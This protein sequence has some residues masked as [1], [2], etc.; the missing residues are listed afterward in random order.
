M[1]S[2]C[3]CICMCVL[4]LLFVPSFFPSRLETCELVNQSHNKWATYYAIVSNPMTVLS[5]FL[6]YY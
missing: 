2:C 1:R 3:V 4:C 6:Q 5:D